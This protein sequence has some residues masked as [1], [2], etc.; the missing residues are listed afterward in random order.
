MRIVI[1]DD[2]ALVRAGLVR[3][4]QGERFGVYRGAVDGRDRRRPP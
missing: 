1:A 3:V 4:L 2:T